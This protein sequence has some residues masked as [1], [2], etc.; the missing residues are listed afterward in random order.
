VLQADTYTPVRYVSTNISSRSA[1]TPG[2][3]TGRLQS[4]W[5][6]SQNIGEG[7]GGGNGMSGRLFDIINLVI[8]VGA[9]WGGEDRAD[10]QGQARAR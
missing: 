9:C 2:A 7:H 4:F 6:N 8:P 5:G 3:Q 1:P 10:P